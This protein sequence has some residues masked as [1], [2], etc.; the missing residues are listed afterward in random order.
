MRHKYVTTGI[1]LSRIPLA[2]ASLLVTILTPEFGLIRA[3]VQGVRTPSAKLSSALQTLC[4]SDLMLVRGKE[5]W[6]IPNAVLGT[7]WFRQLS[8]SAR[9]RAGRIASL[10]QRLVHGEAGDIALYGAFASFLAALPSLS[11]T[12]QDAAE[13]LVA[14]RIVRI[15][16]LDAG[17]IPSTEFVPESLSAIVSD[18]SAIVSRINRGLAASGL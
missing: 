10:I 6:R 4:E 15:L 7:N 2:E 16:G 5:G 14:L 17:E 3:R 9:L 18:R 12:E 11:E 8:R 13:C 1:V